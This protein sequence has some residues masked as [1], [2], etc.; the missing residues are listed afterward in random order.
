M[1]QIVVEF[2]NR[3]KQSE[4]IIPL[5]NTSYDESG[6]DYHN[7]QSEIQQTQ[8]HGI[9]SPLIM[10]NKTIIDFDAV[11][12]FSLKSIGSLPTLS[13]MVSDKFNLIASLD[14][15][16]MDN[17][18][19]IQI[20]PAF[21]GIYKKI[22]MTFFI[23][24]IKV[25]GRN[26]INLTGS[27]KV[28]GLNQS[29][30]KSFGKI[31]SYNLFSNIAKETQL[32]FASNVNN[33]DD[34][35]YVYCDNKNYIELMSKEILHS[36]GDMK[37]YDWWV[38]FWNNINF[39]DI[40]E[41]YNAIDDNDKLK[42]W[43]SGQIGEITEGSKIEPIETEAVINNHPVDSNTELFVKQYNIKTNSNLSINQGTDKL[44]SIFLNERNE[45]MDYLIQDGDI[46]K[47][48]Y[49][50]YEYLGEVY[51]E[52][53]YLLAEKKRQAFMQKINS[54]SVEV[55][56]KSPTLGLMRGHKVNFVW[57]VNDSMLENKKDNLKDNGLLN[58]VET[59]I[60]LNDTLSPEDEEKV[61]ELNGEFNIDK[62]ISGQYLITSNHIRFSNKTGW[63]YIL[64]LNKPAISKTKLLKDD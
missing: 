3:L 38:D 44:Y 64:T 49:C 14:T 17:E 21:D 61:N 18:V 59:N 7:N 27:Y 30:F 53:D 31:N 16:G 8:V 15:P 48:I 35:R 41:R 19:R 63:E 4:I 43:V 20:L 23:S 22:D 57:Y 29:Q 54:E 60:P 58:E 24:S 6:K 46:K 62:A 51:G 37:V 47:D 12:E 39:V 45:H 56:L 32:G 52:Y 1:G 28:P 5:T 55:I 26:I 9:L 50:K 25:V 10:I 36:G 33:T 13:L 42:I 34:E 40:Y 2:D 11:L